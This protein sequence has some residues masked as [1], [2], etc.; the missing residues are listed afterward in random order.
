MEKKIYNVKLE[1][2]A[3]SKEAVEK[4]LDMI[5]C[6]SRTLSFEVTPEDEER[7]VRIAYNKPEDSY[8]LMLSTDGGEEW[9][10]SLGCKCQRGEHDKPDDE[11]MLV[12]VGIIEELK[13]AI[14]NGFDVVY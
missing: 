7:K 3:G 2:E 13:R 14:L 6:D 1:I 10:L 8:D 4:M 5:L 12:S 9:G 11:P